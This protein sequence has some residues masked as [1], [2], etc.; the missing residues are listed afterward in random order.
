M[1]SYEL[2]D[3]IPNIERFEYSPWDVV[4]DMKPVYVLYMFLD[5][6]NA[7]PLYAYR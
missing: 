7:D 6:A 2:P 1:K 4:N 5:L 3:N